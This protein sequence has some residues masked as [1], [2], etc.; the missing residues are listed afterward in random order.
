MRFAPKAHA[1]LQFVVRTLAPAGDRAF[2]HVVR[3]GAAIAGLRRGGKRVAIRSEV[4]DERQQMR[5][6][7][8]SRR[9]R[10]DGP[11]RHPRQG[12]GPMYKAVHGSSRRPFDELDVN[13]LVTGRRRSRSE[14]A[15]WRAG[16]PCLAELDVE[17]SGRDRERQTAGAPKSSSAKHIAT[18]RKATHEPQA[19][20]RDLLK[21][22]GKTRLE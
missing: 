12:R 3:E 14:N 10:A 1:R 18:W 2:S 21:P 22:G 20:D 7:Q 19:A 15:N 5:G 6:D 11:L 9:R 4:S 16:W 17:S 8:T 13:Q